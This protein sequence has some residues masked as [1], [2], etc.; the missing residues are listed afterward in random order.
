MQPRNPHPHFR[1]W[2]HVHNPQKGREVNSALRASLD[3]ASGSWYMN[4]VRPL[5]HDNKGELEK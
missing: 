2:N 1:P 5:T 4:T 3:R